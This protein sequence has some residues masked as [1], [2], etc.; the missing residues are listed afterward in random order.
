M[1]LLTLLLNKY[2]KYI[3]ETE[4]AFSAW[5]LDYLAVKVLQS[6]L[7]SNYFGL[8]FYKSGARKCV[9]SYT[10]LLPFVWRD[11]SELPFQKVL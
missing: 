10:F 9:T 6:L 3:N 5:P 8:S 2:K 7:Q 11:A 1:E 4:K